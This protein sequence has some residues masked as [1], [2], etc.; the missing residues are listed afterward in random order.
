MAWP[1]EMSLVY[2]EWV[3]S[4]HFEGWSDRETLLQQCARGVVRCRTVGWQLYADADSIAIAQTQA[5]NDGV[6]L[7]MQIP[8]VAITGVQTLTVELPVGTA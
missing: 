8:R 2:V 7:V 1:P 6:T 4:N 3:D 5:D